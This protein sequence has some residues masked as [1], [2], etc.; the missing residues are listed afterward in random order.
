MTIW[1]YLLLLTSTS[2][3]VHK[4]EIQVSW[5]KERNNRNI[6]LTELY[7]YKYII[8]SNTAKPLSSV[9]NSFPIGYVGNAFFVKP[10]F[11]LWF[12]T[13]DPVDFLVFFVSWRYGKFT[14]RKK[15][16]YSMQLVSL[17]FKYNGGSYVFRVNNHHTN[18][19][20]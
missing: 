2:L 12:L 8:T 6:F 9:G 7:K 1:A 14:W 19:R 15:K 10:L 16:T 11:T 17:L 5:N 4:K 3:F 20:I 18:Y 13:H